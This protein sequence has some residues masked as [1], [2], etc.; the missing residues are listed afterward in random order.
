ME[1]TIIMFK[2]EKQT[3]STLFRAEI[4]SLSNFHKICLYFLVSGS[5]F[6]ENKLNLEFM[7]KKYK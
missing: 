6:Y 2:V 1:C 7:K 5:L 3:F 4:S